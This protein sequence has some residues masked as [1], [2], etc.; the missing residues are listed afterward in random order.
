M[1]QV[2]QNLERDT[3]CRDI[4]NACVSQHKRIRYGSNTVNNH[5]SASFNFLRNPLYYNS[6]RLSLIDFTCT[7]KRCRWHKLLLWPTGWIVP[8]AIL[9]TSCYTSQPSGISLLSLPTPPPTPPSLHFSFKGQKCSRS[10]WSVL[11]TQV[12]FLSFSCKLF[13]T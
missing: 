7:H 8:T 4:V 12:S 9:F 10:D 6:S 13:S 2:L 11:V 1:A 3:R 5:F